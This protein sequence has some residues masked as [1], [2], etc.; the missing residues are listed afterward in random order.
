MI[1]NGLLRI[2]GEHLK[3]LQLVEESH[4]EIEHVAGELSETVYGQ[5]EA[6]NSIARLL[7][8]A[9]SQLK[10]PNRPLGSVLL[11][12]PTGVGKTATGEAISRYLTRDSDSDTWK[13]RMFKV[14]CTKLSERHMV[15]ELIGAPP[16]YV[17]YGGELLL[18]YDEMSNGAPAVVV[19]DEIEK[20]D[21]A[22]WK[23]LLP[24]LDEARLQV[25]M[26]DGDR[27]GSVDVPF[28]NV[29]NVFTSNI[30]SGAMGEVM[31]TGGGF[32]FVRP[33]TN[34]DKSAIIQKKAMDEMHKTFQY[35][36][37]FPAR[38][39]EIL[40]YKPLLDAHYYQ[41]LDKYNLE[42][43]RVSA[44]QRMPFP[45]LTDECR[46]H[47]VSKATK[48]KRFGAREIRNVFNSDIVS[49]LSDLVMGNSEVA[50][51][52]YLVVHWN[53]EAYQPYI[54][55][56]QLAHD[57]QMTEQLVKNGYE[58]DTIPLESVVE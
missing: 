25:R 38:M 52:D 30:G 36:P 19:W 47:L 57:T 13:R 17:G 18:P 56:D 11:L 2:D 26:R 15:A 54:V 28:N 49:K 33:S 34:E 41:I 37:E 3:N 7:V 1:E 29:F 53:G 16:G 50:Q 51:A 5:D 55:P 21:P 31:R 32:G 48:D 40:V 39:D 45:I 14:D 35:S 42:L 24:V 23:L 43:G 6:M 44:K 9:D 10:P 20:A 12:G 58:Y 8:R 4:S 27:I 22:V 46:D